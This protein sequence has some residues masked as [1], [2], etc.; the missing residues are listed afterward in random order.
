MKRIQKIVA[1]LLS[2]AV[3]MSMLCSC[4][5]DKKEKKVYKD[6]DEHVN[7]VWYVRAT[8]PN[9]FK[10][11]MEAAN[12]YLDEKLNVTLDLRVIDSS[13]YETKM[14]LALASGEDVD[15]IWTA[16]WTFNYESNVLK[17]AFLALDDYLDSPE[18]E[19][20]KNYYSE[21]I[22]DAARV[23]GKIYGMP[24]EQVMYN[25]KSVHFS[26]K[27]YLD[28]Y[29]FTNYYDQIHNMEELTNI[30]QVIKD[31][32]VDDPSFYVIS[33]NQSD[34]FIPEITT[35]SSGWEITG[36]GEVT[37]RRDEYDEYRR[38][39]YDWNKR[40][41]FPPSV[42]T[43]GTED[44]LNILASYS[45]YLPGAEGKSKLGDKKNRDHIL[46]PTTEPFLGRNGIQS[47]LTAV[48]ATSKNPMR[49]LK[50]L[51]LMHTDEYMLN[52]L[53]YG[54]EGRD[55]TKDPDNPKRM[56]REQGGYY[57]G[58]FMIG[59]QF[60]AYLAP[61]YEDDVW[62]ETK[63]ANEEAYVDPNIGFCFDPTSV[64]SEISQVSAIKTEYK[65]IFAYGLEDPEVSIPEY[66]E[67]LEIAGYNRIGDEIRNQY[68]SWKDDNK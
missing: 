26:D 8:E 57:I 31:G 1:M 54:L 38:Q 47:T 20:L 65:N 34:F 41:F 64:E 23:A 7:L 25:Q 40:G 21:G 62:E 30:F 17:N 27:R 53:C 10:E 28:K 11:V 36:D 45:R 43:A 56:N 49:A 66:Y 12:E 22:W 67:K 48:A 16:N 55:Y 19:N 3:M 52:L 39:M 42:T 68:T 13:D 32:E 46:V 61:S 18:L 15:L 9:G 24:M 37:D 2:L 51:Y 5:D 59:S 6:T 4:G 58:E 60:L 63:R 33:T 44:N 50:L 14:Q 29:G 35:V